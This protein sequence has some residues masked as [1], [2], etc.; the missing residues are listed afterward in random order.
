MELSVEQHHLFDIA[1]FY[2]FL[3]R[4]YD[5][6]EPLQF[7]IVGPIGGKTRAIAF[8]HQADAGNLHCLVDADRPHHHALARYDGYKA[9][10]HQMMDCLMNRRAP[11]L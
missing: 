3:R 4:F 7:G 6:L 5:V 9:V 10:H 8:R 1:F 2:D 11:N